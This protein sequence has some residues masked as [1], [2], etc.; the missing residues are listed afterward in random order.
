MATIKKEFGST[1]SRKTDLTTLVF[2]KVPPQACEM[3]EAILGACMLERNAFELAF[4][5]IH[6]EEIFYVDA[7]QKIYA[8]IIFLHNAGYPVDLL[9]VTEQLKK[10]NELELV[11]G[12]YYLTRLTMSVLSSAHV[13]Y[14]A[15]IVFE[16]YALR[17]HIRIAGQILSDAYEDSTDVF[18]LHDL[19]TKQFS[20]IFDGISGNTTVTIGESFKNVIETAKKQKD[21][22][23]EIIGISSGYADL[24]RLTLGWIKTDLII[25]AARPSEGK[26]AFAV[27]FARNAALNNNPILFFCLES[28]DISLTRR[29]ASAHLGINLRSIRTGNLSNSQ[30]IQMDS[31]VSDF[32]KL[33][34]TFDESTM[35]LS[36]IVKVAKRWK[37]N[38]K[39]NSSQLIIIDYLQLIEVSGKQNREQEVAKVSRELKKLAKELDVPIIALSQLNREI[40]KRVNKRP[41]L[42]DIRES[43]AVEQDATT[44]M[45]IW[46]K[47]INETVKELR[48]VVLKNREGETGE[49]LLKMDADIQKIFDINDLNQNV[50]PSIFNTN[51]QNPNLPYKDNDNEPWD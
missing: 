25:L 32:F 22:K 30:M 17:E 7:H 41:M 18:D 6:N 46:W 40:E 43:G 39:G 33:P 27:N 51:F 12:A 2:G 1:R 15:R 13:E 47:I 34:I 11:G 45:A 50:H 24:D 36:G 3:E 38:L 31:S 37:K 8:A 26:T 10:T 29:I 23:T 16:K 35:T 21:L 48:I 49:A 5:I 19:A 20:E 9:T 44:L 14:H 28:T 4:E 42:S